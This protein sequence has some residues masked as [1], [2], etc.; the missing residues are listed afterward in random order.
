[1][2][3]ANA[4]LIEGYFYFLIVNIPCEK[5]F[6]RLSICDDVESR[7]KN[8]SRISSVMSREITLSKLHLDG[9]CQSLRTISRTVSAETINTAAN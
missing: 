5:D 9:T 6:L 3:S 8:I 1:M 2:I 4:V 7:V